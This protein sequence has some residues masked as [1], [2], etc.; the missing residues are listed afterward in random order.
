MPDLNAPGIAK[1]IAKQ[2]NDDID[3]YCKSAYDDGHRNH[4]GASLI[5][6]D[7]SRYLWYVFRWCKKEDFS[8]RMQ[9]LF[10]RGHKEESR[11]IE[12]LTAIGCQVWSDDNG[13][14]F[15]ISGVNGHFGGSL[16]GIAKLPPSY[17]IDEPVLLEFKTS[18][19]GAGFNKLGESGMAINKPQHYAQTSTYGAKYGFNFVLY[20]CINKNDDSIHTELVKLDHNLGKQMELKAE[21]I[22]A[23]QIPPNK[24]SEQSTYHKCTYCAMKPIC[25]GADKPDLNCR[26]CKMAYPFDNGQWMCAQHNAIIPDDVIKTGCPQYL[27]IVN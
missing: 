19:T 10:N 9:R 15:R 21:K 6:H 20:M 4:L 24:L 16:D 23:S 27:S 3:A 13:K 5:G 25:H 18:G 1:Q 11:F 22:I 8:G 17:G 7:C 2:I 12:W 14:Q 26:S